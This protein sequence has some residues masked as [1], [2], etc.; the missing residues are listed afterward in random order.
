MTYIPTP[1]PLEG[2]RY[3][4]GNGEEGACF[5]EEWPL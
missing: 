1:G 4:P 3:E 5:I 2:E